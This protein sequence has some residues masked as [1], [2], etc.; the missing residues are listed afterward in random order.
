[1]GS[2]ARRITAV[3]AAATAITAGLLAVPTTASAAALGSCG[4]S[5]GKVGSYPV[6]RAWEGTAGHIDVYYSRTTGK[7]CA[8]TRPI[9]SLS[10]KA[11]N[12]WVCIEQTRG[13]A[14]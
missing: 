14:R 8:I 7:N 3:T 11:G 6:T 4:S 12:L 1:M 2:T 10:G 9:S 5:Y 13:N